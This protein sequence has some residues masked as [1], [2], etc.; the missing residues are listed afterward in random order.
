MFDLNTV[1]EFSRTH[2]ISIC[3]FLVP[4][5]LVATGLTVA[6]TLLRRPK[7]QVWKAA[8]IAAI[9][10]LVM[11]FHVVTWFMIG[12]VMAPTYI[13]LWLAATCLSINLWAI[14]HPQSMVRLI[15]WAWGMI[16][17]AFNRQHLT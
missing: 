14:S 3:A 17:P 12:V 8:A 10:A 9:P 15:K 16:S 5:N 6:F 13:L 7:A 2:C 4:A 1:S 11:V